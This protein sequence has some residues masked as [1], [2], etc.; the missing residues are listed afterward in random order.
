[1][2]ALIFWT[3]TI[4]TICAVASIVVAIVGTIEDELRR[5]KVTCW[6]AC[7]VFFSLAACIGL[8]RG[9]TKLTAAT[10]VPSPTA[11]LA[12]DETQ[13]GQSTLPHPIDQ[14]SDS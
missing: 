6:I 9:H 12:V 8:L 4:A 1:M 3:I 11:E 10:E 5:T 14:L 7:I 13:L 2:T